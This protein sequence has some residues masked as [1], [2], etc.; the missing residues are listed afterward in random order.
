MLKRFNLLIFT[1]SVLALTG[2]WDPVPDQVQIINEGP[3]RGLYKWNHDGSTV[4]D[5]TE[6]QPTMTACLNTNSIQV[7]KG[8]CLNPPLGFQINPAPPSK[9]VCAGRSTMQDQACQY[10]A[11]FLYVDPG[12]QIGDA[13][14]SIAASGVEFCKNQDG[15]NVPTKHCESQ[16]ASAPYKTFFAPILSEQKG[17]QVSSGAASLTGNTIT[18][19]A[20]VGNSGVSISGSNITARISVNGVSIK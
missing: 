20:A 16:V 15:V 10:T 2:C 19:R 18:M 7:Q 8:V 4:V 11:T 9:R 12:L 1:I 13:T 14:V 6:I 3:Y 17:I 5:E